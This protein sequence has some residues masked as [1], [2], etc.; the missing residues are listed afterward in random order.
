MSVAGRSVGIVV[1]ALAI[2]AQ[3]TSA[4]NS[5]GSAIVEA[6]AFSAV[7]AGDVRVDYRE[8]TETNSRLAAEIERALTARGFVLRD[9]PSLL[10][11]LRT[12]VRRGDPGGFRLR[13]YGE[14]GSRVGLNDFK[15][16]I[17]LPDPDN[18]RRVVRYEVYMDLIDRE[19][20]QIVWTGK[21]TIVVEGAERF[22][23]TSDLAKRL[24]DLIGQTTP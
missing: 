7:R 1:A 2:L 23:V 17:D 20:R 22:Q 18:E 10:L 13:F 6:R 12:S 16:G 11:D 24:T 9:R 3:P 5:Q 15:V 8:N 4:Q 14:G 21:A 19:A